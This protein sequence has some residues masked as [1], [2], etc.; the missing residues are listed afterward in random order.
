MP[1]LT[2]H[3]RKVEQLEGASSRDF[4]PLDEVA[5][6]VGGGV[7][8]TLLSRGLYPFVLLGGLLVDL[9]DLALA[10]YFNLVLSLSEAANESASKQKPEATGPESY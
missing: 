9:V 3:S 7:S 2:R 5:N 4:P 8:P 10:R 1:Y 6:R